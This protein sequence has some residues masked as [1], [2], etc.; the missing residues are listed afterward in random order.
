MPQ[1][2]LSLIVNAE[3]R[4]SHVLWSERM[5]LGDMGFSVSVNQSQ[6]ERIAEWLKLW[7]ASEPRGFTEDGAKTV[8]RMLSKVLQVI[9]MHQQH[10]EWRRQCETDEWHYLL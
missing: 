10:G 4:I 9:T 5:G 3:G 8:E 6:L 2:I 7:M 1:V